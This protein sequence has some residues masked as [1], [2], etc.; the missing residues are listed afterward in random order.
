LV[1]KKL[2]GTNRKIQYIKHGE[3]LAVNITP[4]KHE[5]SFQSFYQNVTV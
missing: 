2:K 4:D 5:Q 1:L 3:N